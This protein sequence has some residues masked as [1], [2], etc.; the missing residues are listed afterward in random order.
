MLSHRVKGQNS[1]VTSLG[2]LLFLQG[3]F[4]L[5]SRLIDHRYFFATHRYRIRL[6]LGLLTLAWWHG[7]RPTFPNIILF[8]PLGAIHFAYLHFYIMLL[9]AL[10]SLPHG[11]PV[12]GSHPRGIVHFIDGV[13]LLF[14]MAKHSFSLVIHHTVDVWRIHILR[15]LYLLLFLRWNHL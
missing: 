5:D 2:L 12:F 6:A 8:E 11:K 1:L 13:N 14:N 15:I 10:L 9:L 3:W 4:D 7:K